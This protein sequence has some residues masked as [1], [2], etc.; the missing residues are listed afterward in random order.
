MKVIIDGVVYDSKK[1]P[2][3]LELSELEKEHIGN[4]GDQS[5]YLSCPDETTSQ[6][7]ERLIRQDTS[8]NTPS[9]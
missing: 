3:L 5:R 4:M 1:T 8:D 9:V 7:M 2:I 6:E